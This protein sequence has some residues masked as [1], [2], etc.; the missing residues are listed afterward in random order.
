MRI[1]ALN[2]NGFKSFC[3]DTRINFDH[4]LTAV[5]GPNGCGKSN[6]VDAI[7]WALGEQSAK[8]LRGRGMEDVIFN[9]SKNRG[10]Q[11]LAEVTIT[12]H[13]DDGLSHQAYA[14]YPEIA[15]TRR[16]H[17]D[18]TSE[19]LINKT[20]CRLKDVFDLF[21]GTGGGARAY[22]IIEQGR[23]GLIVSS[24][25]E[26]RRAMIEEAAGITRYKAARRLAGRKMDQTRQHL[27]RV[28]DVVAEMERN[29]SHLKRQARKAERVKRHQAEQLDQELWV[30]SHRFLE[31]RARTTTLDQSL[32]AAEEELDTGRGE[33]R[34]AEARMA[35]CRVSE[36]ESRLA[37]DRDKVAAHG[38]DTAIL[39]IESDLG[40][41]RENLER[42]RGEE[43]T[44]AGLEAESAGRLRALEEE[45]EAL[46]TRAEEIERDAQ[47][48]AEQRGEAERL[49]GEARQR[50]AELGAAY[51]ARR[52]RM[53]RA[54]ARIAASDSVLASLE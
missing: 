25:S 41:L 28:T 27:L 14:D 19:Y 9:G 39:R 45:R 17:R 4:S 51:D 2:I 15:V 47:H 11:S 44:S 37:L 38:I 43:L 5:V 22:S 42:L 3:D 46:A 10:A 48:L 1:K 32:A 16:L 36:Q 8:N 13:N 21:M 23:I 18:G 52:D 31:L 33:L 50:L 53:S 34:A 54:R 49:A 12:F 29:L 35:A 20:A 6:I 40:H 7:R 30:A 26:D 24:R